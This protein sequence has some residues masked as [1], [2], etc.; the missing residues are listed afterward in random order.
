MEP[1]GRRWWQ[2]VAKWEGADNGPEQTKTVAIDE[3]RHYEIKVAG[4]TPSH[5]KVEAR[6]HHGDEVL[7][8]S[9]HMNRRHELVGGRAT[10]SRMPTCNAVSEP[11]RT[12]TQTR[13]LA[14]RASPRDYAEARMNRPPSPAGASG[15]L[16][17]R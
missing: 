1:S 5:M 8:A 9:D 3:M 11:G 17:S 16:P 4:G 15:Y 7:T 2:P 6:S 12:A 10:S 14:T 13:L